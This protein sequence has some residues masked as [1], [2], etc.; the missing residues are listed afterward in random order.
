M[1]DIVLATLNARYIHASLGLRY[2]LAN[3]GEL[4]P[5]AAIAEFEIH[6]TALGIVEALLRQ[7][8]RIVGFGVYI[9]NVRQTCDVVALLKRLR[10]EVRVVLGGPEVSHETE[11]QEIVRLADHVITGEADLAFASLC[12]DLLAGNGDVNHPAGRR[13]PRIIAAPLPNVAELALPYAFY[14]EADIAGRV[15]YVEASR[16]CPF[17]CE[18]CLSSLDIPVRQFPLGAFLESLGGLLDRGARQFKFVDRTFNL[19]LE[20]SRA[21]LRFFRERWRHDLFL[22]FEMI[23]DRLPDPLREEIAWFPP[24]SVQLEVGLQSLNPDVC[25]RIQRRQNLQRVEDNLRFLRERAGAH[26]HADLI[27]GLPGEDLASFAAG[28]DRLLRMG[29]HE[30][31]VGILKR[32]RGTPIVRHDEEWGMRYN[33]LPPYDILENRLLSFADVQ[34]L[35]RFARYWD[36]LANSGRFVTTLPFLWR[37][38]RSPFW[39][40]MEFSDALFTE[41]GQTHAINPDRLARLLRD[42]L[43]HRLGLPAEE[44]DAALAADYRRL[45]RDL[46]ASL[47]PSKQVPPRA[48]RAALPTRQ[49]RHHAP[50]R[51]PVRDPERPVPNPRREAAKS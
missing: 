32:L 20:V 25:A 2:L 29:P 38:D 28:F 40:F 16:G 7:N 49:A 30:I 34:R 9:W 8:P 17:R 42:W 4:Q 11:D 35:R 44:V 43:V 15:L 3:L 12:R 5:R 13:P 18:F 14:S 26:I 33:P 45:G 23:P 6:Q 39:S 50:S 21:I 22:H 41:T 46:P 37:G 31:Q 24:G 51:F 27:A 10:P 36:L 47:H 19:N 48:R 1:P